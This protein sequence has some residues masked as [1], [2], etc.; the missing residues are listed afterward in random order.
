MGVRS[1]QA[2]QTGNTL[3]NIVGMDGGGLQ[4]LRVGYALLKNEPMIFIN[5]SL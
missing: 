1:K 4:G 5:L 2:F 3:K